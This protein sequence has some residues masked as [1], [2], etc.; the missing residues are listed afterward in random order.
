MIGKHMNSNL[1][2]TGDDELGDFH[3][4]INLING[5]VSIDDM[6]SENGTWLRLSN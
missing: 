4:K 1:R 2:I 3:A 5:V 6:A